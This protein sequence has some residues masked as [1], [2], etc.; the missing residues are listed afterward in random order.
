MAKR[1]TRTSSARQKAKRKTHP[2]GAAG[3]ARDAWQQAVAAVVA[4]EQ[5]A[6]SRVR[7]LLHENQIGGREAAVVVKDLQARFGRERRRAGKNLDRQLKA[8]QV[9]VQHERK[10]AGERVAEL[11]QQTLASLNIPSRREIAELTRKV[12]QLSRKIDTLKRRK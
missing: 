6:Q 4:A 5:Q 11:V 7:R 12:E 10:A 3:V 2:R 1:K 9:R 8:L